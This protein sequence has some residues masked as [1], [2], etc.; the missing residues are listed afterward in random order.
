MNI[1]HISD[2]HFGPYHWRGD[3]A[4]VLRRLNA[5][6]ADIVLNTGDSTSDSLEVEFQ[7]VENFLAQLT[8]PN[9]I[10][11]MGNHESDP[12]SLDTEMA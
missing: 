10:S 7:Q 1:L 6:P 3:D 11:I 8:C 5:F 9:V 4:A 2:I 12:I